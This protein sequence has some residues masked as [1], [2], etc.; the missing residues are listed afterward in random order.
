VLALP[1]PKVGQ[2]SE[3]SSPTF[4]QRSRGCFA[5]RREEASN[6]FV[7]SSLRAACFASLEGKAEA[8][9]EDNIVK[10]L[11]LLNL[12]KALKSSASAF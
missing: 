6:P 11:M 8:F 4:G 3:A 5:S 9:L 10:F 7:A 2:R 1:S 12:T